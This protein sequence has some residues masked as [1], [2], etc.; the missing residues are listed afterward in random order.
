[1]PT[2]KPVTGLLI[3]GSLTKTQG[4]LIQ[5]ALQNQPFISNKKSKTGRL[6]TFEPSSH[7]PLDPTLYLKDNSQDMISLINGLASHVD[8]YLIATTTTIDPLY[9]LFLKATQKPFTVLV[10][11]HVLTPND[12]AQC[13]RKAKDLRKRFEERL[14]NN[15]PTKT[16]KTP[17]GGQLR[18]YQQQMVDFALDKKRC[19]LFADMGLGKTLATLAFL[20]ELFIKNLVDKTKPVLIVAP[21]TVALDTWSREAAEWGYD[22]DVKINIQLTPKKR[23]KLLETLTVPQEKPTLVTT[24]SEQLGKIAAY[25]DKRGLPYPFEVVIIDEL[26]MFKSHDTK[27]F[28]DVQKL[29]KNIQYFVGLT[30][31]PA[32]AS[33]LNLWS[34]MIIIDPSNMRYFTSDFYIYRSTYFKPTSIDPRTGRV[35]KYGLKP[36]AKEKIIENLKHTVMALKTE[37]RVDL[38]SI[39]YVNKYIKL[40]PKAKRI[41]DDFDKKLRNILRKTNQTTTMHGIKIA[42]SAI[43]KMKLLQLSSG[44][45]YDNIEDFDPTIIDSNDFNMNVKE[46]HYTSYHDKK[47]EAIKEYAE[48]A[49]SPIL[50]F[51]WF[52]SEAERLKKYIDY[53]YLDA[54]S[55]NFSDTITKWN[56]GEIPILLCHPFSASHGL[57]IQHGGHTIIW[58]TPP[59]SNE[60]YRQANKRLHRNG[61]KHPVT[62]IHLLAEGTEDIKVINNLNKQE[63]DQQELMTTLD[64]DKPNT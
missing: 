58:M 41:Y 19:G 16:L 20:N 7:M 31:T 8:R 6:V 64:P 29:T 47:L 26:S 13:I 62:V 3:D 5:K 54:H 50:V 35:F 23:E 18:P 9:L 53:V 59:A 39:T 27:K 63:T 30:G 55:P 52:K 36:G 33:Y 17:N 32:P 12:M 43:L 40:P 2:K 10:D 49:T 46:K 24:N 25:F 34:Q 4:Q 45:I 1:M 21:I 44:A 48:T 51:F 22:F 28:T 11:D 61:Q 42:N 60:R 15:M 14:N 38:P 57:N 37:G 56:K